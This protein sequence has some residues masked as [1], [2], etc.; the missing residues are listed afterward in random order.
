[1]EPLFQNPPIPVDQLPAIKEVA[2]ERVAP[3]Y[4]TTSYI[5]TILFFGFLFFGLAMVLLFSD[6][7]KMPLLAYAL[8]GL[9]LGLFL[10][11]LLLVRKGYHRMGYALRDRDILFRKGVLFHRLTTIPFNRVQHC[12]VQQGPVERFFD[13]KTLEIYTA[14]GQSSDLKI[15]GLQ[16]D[17]AERLKAFIMSKTT[18]D[19][20]EREAI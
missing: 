11:S 2:F 20:S 10:M 13:L 9:W 19:D 15:P 14:G 6:I 12:E 18:A 4:V 8:Q 3:A 7:W 5:G 1:M 17:Q 16:G